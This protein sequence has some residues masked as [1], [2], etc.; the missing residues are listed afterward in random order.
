MNDNS[1]QKCTGKNITVVVI[2]SGISK[3]SDI[4]N[5]PLGMHIYE[6]N[7][8]FVIDEN[9]EDHVGHGTAVYGI[10]SKEIS[11]AKIF[12]VKLVEQAF[13]LDNKM[14]LLFALEYIYINVPCNIILIELG[15]S[16]SDILYEN[17][18]KNLCEKL[19]EKG[20]IIVNP[21]HNVGSLSIPAR[22]ES[23]IGVDAD[24]QNR[25]S[26][27]YT[28]IEGAP[29]NVY[30]KGTPE[31]VLWKDNKYGMMQG[32]SFSAAHIVAVIAKLMEH[33][34]V[35]N[36]EKVKSSLKECAH[37]IIVTS[38]AEPYPMPQYNI[39]SAILFPFNKEMH[40]VIRFSY[41]LD[42][43]IF[44]VYTNKYTGQIG[45]KV[46]DILDNSDDQTIIKSVNDIDWNNEF[47]TIILG[48]CDKLE[49]LSDNMPQ[50]ENLILKA[51]EYNK[52]IY[53][54]DEEYLN[55]FIK[56]GG[57]SNKYYFPFIESI[58]IPENFLGKL[59]CSSVPILAFLGT[60]AR[61]GKFSL[62]LL[63]KERFI[64][65]NYK[66]GHIVTEPTGY[67]FGCDCVYPFGYKSC[68]KVKGLDAIKTL[69]KIIKDIEEKEPDII[70]V[71]SQSGT[72]PLHHYHASGLMVQQ[73]EFIIGTN[74]DA[75]ILC[76][77]G[78][79]DME[80]I[81]KNISYIE[82]VCGTKVIGVSLYPYRKKT[83]DNKIAF[84]DYKMNDTDICIYKNQ[85]LSEI[86]IPCFDMTQKEDLDK[87]FLQII[88]F[89]A[90]SS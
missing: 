31:R 67:L 14:R 48:H 41:L 87:M 74:P 16:T 86:N 24:I 45:R 34:S 54:F 37:K 8:N 10:L 56:N 49:S 84:I 22:F 50:A 66:V 79:I 36:L 9:I 1:W 39:K 83:L 12:M 13:E 21:F 20:I 47:D 44:G 11:S 35:F 82:N 25:K 5:Q 26:D 6:K 62:Q 65:A 71:G 18:L 68:V 72:V 38:E 70:F 51:I 29:I 52:N 23:V 30:G 64:H 46:K 88:N 55:F 7:K 69:N 57:N 42:F 85:V 81:S 3:H 28:Y 60:D 75:S 73:Y 77:N 90:K 58:H 19:K 53:A 59:Y 76:V 33:Y 78:N 2:D 40:A 63:L 43:E 15:I 61:Q 27:L 80:H 17:K 89:F 4:A 32:T